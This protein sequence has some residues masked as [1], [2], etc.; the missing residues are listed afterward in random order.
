MRI[1]SRPHLK[2]VEIKQLAHD[3]IRL[4]KRQRAIVEQAVRDVC[5]HRKYRLRAINVRSNHAHTVASALS[6]PE[7]I[8]EAFKSYSTRALRET[9]ILDRSIKPWTRHGSTIYLRKERDVEK[10]VEYVLL[11]QDHE[12]HL[13]ELEPSLTVGLVSRGR[14]C[15]IGPMVSPLPRLIRQLS[16]N[17]TDT[18][19]QPALFP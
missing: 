7:P 19:T 2:Q 13:I 9:G 17:E 10:A 1:P 16:R 3:P 11:G 12:F 4:N 15:A 14:S 5:H 18:R 8:L 6:D